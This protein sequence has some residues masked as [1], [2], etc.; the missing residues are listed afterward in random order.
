MPEI[1]VT[2]EEMEIVLLVKKKQLTYKKVKNFLGLFCFLL[3]NDFFDCKAG[4]KR[5]M[6]DGDGKL[7]QIRTEQI[8]WKS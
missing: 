6:F 2:E 7:R 3:E 8:N 1:K 4:E 5:V